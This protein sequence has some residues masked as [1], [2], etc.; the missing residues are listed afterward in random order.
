MGIGN[1]QI[2]RIGRQAQMIRDFLIGPASGCQ[3][4]N[5]KLCGG[6]IVRHGITGI[7]IIN[8][9][10]ARGKPVGNANNAFKI[11]GP[12]GLDHRLQ[13]TAQKA[14]VLAEPFDQI[15]RPGQPPGFQQMLLC[16]LVCFRL[17]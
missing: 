13:H 11:P 1:F 12:P 10:P 6:E 7:G 15:I 3:H 9:T 8:L 16:Q 5:G 14:V 4:G 2:N 17:M